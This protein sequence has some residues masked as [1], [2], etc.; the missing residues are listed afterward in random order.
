MAERM[1]M[2]PKSKMQVLQEMENSV[3]VHR[4]NK[5][6]DLE[7]ENKKRKPYEMCIKRNNSINAKREKR[8]VDV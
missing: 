5:R 7:P 3:M 4:R 2:V 8:K 1:E 6:A